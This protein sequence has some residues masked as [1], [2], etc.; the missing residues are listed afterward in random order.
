MSGVS[1]LLVGAGGHS[2]AV[3]EAIVAKGDRLGAYVDPVAASWLDVRRFDTDAAAFEAA[4][5][6][7]LVMGLGGVSAATLERRLA[8]LERYL[9]S[10]RAAPPVVHPAAYVSPQARLEAGVIVLAGAI[11]QPAAVIEAGALVNTGAI[12][13]HDTRLGRGS[14]LAP[15]AILL[16]GVSVGRC[17]M[18][19]AGAVVLLGTEI[20]DGALVPA[21]VRYPK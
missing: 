18:I 3:V 13:E 5:P 6:E 11:V 15:R 1:L 4:A 16:G 21:G 2:K 17:A 7:A 14:H 8:L 12:V 10:G 9:A 20:A 19:G